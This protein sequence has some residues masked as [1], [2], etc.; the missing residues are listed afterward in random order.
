L[1]APRIVDKLNIVHYIGKIFF[2]SG[3]EIFEN[4]DCITFR[5]QGADEIRP[6]ESSSSR[7]QHSFHALSASN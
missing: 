1:D 6:D 2:S 4:S 3:G 5:D 7:H